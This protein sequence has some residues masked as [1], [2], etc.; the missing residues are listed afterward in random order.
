[1][2]SSSKAAAILEKLGFPAPGPAP[3]MRL[4]RQIV[5]K[6]HAA[7]S[8]GGERAHDLI[9]LQIAVSDAGIDYAKARIACIRPFAYKAEPE[10]PPTISKGESRDSLYA[11]QAAGLDVLPSVDDAVVWANTLIARI[12]ESC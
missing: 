4:E 9:D 6:F 7:S 8:A 12:E 10:C 3:C 11:A 5:Q 1:M 2:V